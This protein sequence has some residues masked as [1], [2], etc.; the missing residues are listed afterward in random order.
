MKVGLVN[1]FSTQLFMFVWP[2]L[3]FSNRVF[4]EMGTVVDINYFIDS[5]LISP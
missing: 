2:L 4:I 3:L 5:F 1:T